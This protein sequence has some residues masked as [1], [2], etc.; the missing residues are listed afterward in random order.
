[1]SP[2]SSPFQFGPLPASPGQ[3]CHLTPLAP[4]AQVLALDCIKEVTESAA[5]SSDNNDVE[6]PADNTNTGELMIGL[7]QLIRNASEKINA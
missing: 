4:V 2:V 5:T 1:M 6:A 7:M 3:E